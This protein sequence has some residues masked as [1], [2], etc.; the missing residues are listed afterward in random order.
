MESWEFLSSTPLQSLHS[1]CSGYNSF[2]VH[3]RSRI[4]PSFSSL[5]LTSRR[6]RLS[7]DEGQ[8][9]KNDQD[10]KCFLN[11]CIHIFM[12][13]SGTQPQC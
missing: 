12:E 7:D 10:L 4:F 11:M 3:W 5:N 8:I 6:P 13:A 9:H 1:A 2:S